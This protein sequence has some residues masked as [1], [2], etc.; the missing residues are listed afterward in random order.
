MDSIKKIHAHLIRT[1]FGTSRYTMF[2][3]ASGYARSPSHLTKAILV[4][5]STEKPSTH[6]WNSI[7]RDLV[8]GGRVKDGMLIYAGMR[9]QRCPP[10]HLTFIFLLKG[11]GSKEACRDGKKLHLQ[12]L[13]LGFGSHVFV[14]NA[15]IHMY[16]VCGDL[17]CARMLFD[18][19]PNRDMVSWNSLIC[20]FSREKKLREVLDLFE[21]MQAENAKPDE[22]TMMKV[23][24]ACMHLGDW[25]LADSM[26]RYIE[27]N[28]VKID[29]FLGNTLID[30]HGRRGSVNL[31]RK[32]FDKMAEK[33]IV[34]WNSLITGYSKAGDL[35]SA[36]KLF[37]EMPAR[38]LISWTSIIAGYCFTNRFA[39]ALSFF[40]KMMLAKV[41]PDEITLSSVLSACAHVGSLDLGTEIH[42]YIL[43][44][45]IKVDIYLGNSL[46]DMYC[47]CGSIEK[48]KEVFNKMREK[49]VVSWTSVISGMAV[50]GYAED[51]LKFFSQMLREGVRP[52]S[53]TFVGVLLACSHCGLVDRGFECFKSMTEVY[54]IQPQMKHYG[55]MVDL[56]SRSGL[57]DEAFSFINNMP[58]DPDP[59]IW[60]ILMSACLLH[61]NVGLSEICMKKALELDPNNSGNYV[62][63]SNAYASAKRWND[64]SKA[65]EMME[66]HGVQKAPG[67]SSIE[68]NGTVHELINVD[69]TAGMEKSCSDV[70]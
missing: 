57:L 63:L 34:S 49:D 12:I 8:N 62:L 3:V 47:K 26:V 56:L 66:D 10:N 45:S 23:L 15:L 44:N 21:A 6:A 59:M 16:G 11:C 25:D 31:A 39:D 17:G 40:Q 29:L 14:S 48:A 46:I 32:V 54:Q 22:V 50:N 7:I 52:S 28:N 68:I 5:S 53:V 36:R 19:I 41:K 60:R 70:G 2:D 38:D 24:L 55:C 20:A 67:C 51:A 65:R 64:S 37:D 18:G 13:K 58:V 27:E 35:V 42:D 33:N 43:K 4:L 61:G 1:G 69:M 9:R 30:L